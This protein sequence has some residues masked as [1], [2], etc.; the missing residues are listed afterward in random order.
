VSFES[1][2]NRLHKAARFLRRATGLADSV[3]LSDAA[4]AFL[5][6]AL[7]EIH[8]SAF[9]RLAQD[10]LTNG[11]SRSID[12]AI[13]LYRGDLL[14]DNPYEEWLEYDRQRLRSRLRELLRASGCFHRL[15]AVDPTDED[16][17]VAIMRAMMRSG[18]RSGV[19]RQY[20]Q[21][22]RML[23]EELGVEPGPEA[24]AFARPGPD[25]PYAR[26]RPAPAPIR[27]R[28]LPHHWSHPMLRLPPADRSS[29]TCP[30]L[31][32]ILRGPAQFPSPPTAVLHPV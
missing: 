29:S 22:S 18:D 12:R 11:D 21:L 8:V 30:A 1:V 14:P 3:V 4:D 31:T 25:R 9:A 20:A 17:H 15:I 24:H 27:R 7:V 26:F 23:N 19:L 13:A 5:P 28:L 32:R 2:Q 10:G 6:D 16:G